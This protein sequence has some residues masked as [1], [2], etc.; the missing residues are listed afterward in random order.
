MANGS[1]ELRK[2]VNYKGNHGALLER[3][4]KRTDTE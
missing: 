1:T 3:G 2:K 4:R